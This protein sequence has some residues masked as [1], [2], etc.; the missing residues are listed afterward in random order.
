MR[1]YKYACF[2]QKG[3]SE[4]LNP[5]TIAAESVMTAAGPAFLGLVCDSSEAAERMVGWFYKDVLPILRERGLGVL[6]KNGFLRHFS[7]QNR[8]YSYGVVIVFKRR[9][10]FASRGKFAFVRLSKGS[11]SICGWTPEQKNGVPETS[12]SFTHIRKND[13]VLITNSGFS[14]CFEPAEFSA[15]FAYAET[16][17][18]TEEVLSSLGRRA[19]SR[20][21]KKSKAVL[22]FGPERAKE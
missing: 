18:E 22:Y 4:P 19:N 1:E 16:L 3:E 14:A 6:V 2:W 20:G 10:F 13:S 17:T 9:V 8:P 12:C 7:G 5:Y 11:C 21:L 15:A